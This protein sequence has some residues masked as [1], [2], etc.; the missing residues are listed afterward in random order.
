MSIERVEQAVTQLT[1]TVTE[2]RID[3]A[4]ALARIEEQHVAQGARFE[5]VEEDVEELA[6]DVQAVQVESEVNKKVAGS[7]GR[8]WGAAVGVALIALA[9]TVK[10]WLG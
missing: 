2:F 5:A 10:A 1:E 4:S 9:E 8:R 3:T 6:D 7:L